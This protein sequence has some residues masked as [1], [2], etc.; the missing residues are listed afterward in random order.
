MTHKERDNLIQDNSRHI[1]TLNEEMGGVRERLTSIEANLEW[2][3]WMI[4]TSAGAAIG[5]LIAGVVNLI[6]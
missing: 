5:S 4:R 6:K 1:A 2:Q 3:R